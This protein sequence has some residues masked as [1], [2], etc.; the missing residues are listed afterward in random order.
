MNL[1]N[2]VMSDKIQSILT[3]DLKLIAKDYGLKDIIVEFD[4]VK[5]F[6]IRLPYITGKNVSTGF[7]P[8]FFK[9]MTEKGFLIF[10]QY[11]NNEDGITMCGKVTKQI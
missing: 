9:T 8:E 7:N 2:K 11:A 6:S 10:W 4:S 3:E 1:F 5:D